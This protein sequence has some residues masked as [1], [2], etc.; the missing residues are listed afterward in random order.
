MKIFNRFS[1]TSIAIFIWIFLFT[2]CSNSEKQTAFRVEN[3]NSGWKIQTRD[4][5]AQINESAISQNDFDV[6][7]WYDGIVPGTVMGALTE[8]SVIGDP[9]FG[10][11]M[12]KMDPAQF[13]KPWWY[14][15]SFNIS[16]DDLKKNVSL[17]FNGICYRAD[18]WVNGKKVIGM[19][20]FA[21][22]YRIFAFN[23]SP[24][25]KEGK[26]TMALKVK[27][28]A[29]GEYSLGFCD[30]NPLPTDRSMGI[31]REV[32][33]EINEGIKIRSPFVY[34]KVDSVS[35]SVS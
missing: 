31:F 15:T 24:Y 28:F 35:K 22:T 17:R 1:K 5:L 19:D 6:S 2:A 4:K 26:N 20:K 7:G 8:D 9:T 18:L 33:L 14:R 21:G 23:I 3:I 11:N 34:S 30:W 13:Q 32:F 25:I 27:Q 29:D 12:K 16:A 10:I